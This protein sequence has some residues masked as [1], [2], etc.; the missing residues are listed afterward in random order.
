MKP[1]EID[2]NVL[3]RIDELFNFIINEFKA[4]DTAHCY[5]ENIHQ[6]L[7]KLGGN[8]SLVKCRRKKWREKGFHCAVFNHCWVFA[9]KIYDDRVIIHDMEYA[10]NI[11][12]VDY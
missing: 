5:I 11:K 7:Q 12:D 6:F 2:S 9:Y 10:A 1:V 3:E 4:P 8:F